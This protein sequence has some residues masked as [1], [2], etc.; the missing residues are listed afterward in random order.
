M[1]KLL[2]IRHGMTNLQKEERFWGNTDIPLNELGLKQAEQLRDRLA[3]EKITHYYSSTLSRARDTAKII[4]AGRRSIVACKELCECNFGYL[5]GL[6]YEEIKRLHP[7]V[8]EELVKMES[9]D[10]PGG[11][12]LEKFHA[13]LETFLKRLEKHKPQDVIAIIAHGG[14]L[15]MLIC[16]LLGLE[17]KHWHRMHIDR[18]SLSIVDTYPVVNILDSLNDTSHLMPKKKLRNI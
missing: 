14:S 9:I 2:L 11:E 16:H 8:A 13:R 10:F 15:R 12:S 1:P 5:E 4:A 3:S 17:I 7:A 18:G 6:T